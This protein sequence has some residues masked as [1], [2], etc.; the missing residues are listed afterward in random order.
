MAADTVT[1]QNF[2]FHPAALTVAA[3]AT[4]TFRAR[5]A[6]YSDEPVCARRPFVW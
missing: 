2:A 4:K 1:I 3:G 6:L 5:R